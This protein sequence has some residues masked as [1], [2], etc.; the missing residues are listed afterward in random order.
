ML[1]YYKKGDELKQIGKFQKHCWINIVKPTHHEL[2][3]I[4]GEYDLDYHKLLAGIDEYEVPRHDGN[5]KE[6]YVYLNST[7]P[8]TGSTLQT[9]LIVITKE[10]IMTI[11]KHEPPFFNQIINKEVVLETNDPRNCLLTFMSL[12]IQEYEKETVSIAKSV[13]THKTIAKDLTEKELAN[14]LEEEDM[15]NDY[16]ASYYY[17]TLLFE[18]LKD[19]LKKKNDKKMHELIVEARQGSNL[20]KSTLKTIQNVR[21]YYNIILNNRLNKTITVLTIFTIFLAIPAAISGLYGMNITLPLQ[22]HPFAFHL[23]L[24]IC[25]VLGVSLFLYIRKKRI[26]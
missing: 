8:E 10:F 9:M 14:L 24:V 25:A 20:C 13:Q 21:E 26:I 2:K 18:R 1:T 22:R 15:M 23:I 4:A 12:I 17:L 11:V 16:V 3:T 7:T 5:A 19:K 6:E